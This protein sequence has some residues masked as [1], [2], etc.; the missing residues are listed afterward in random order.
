MCLNSLIIRHLD[1]LGYNGVDGSPVRET[2]QGLD[3]PSGGLS[4]PIGAFG[5]YG[6]SCTWTPKV[7]KIMAFWA[8]FSG[9]GPLFY[10]LWGSR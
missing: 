1:P 4:G 3:N 5:A 6:V 2:T 8:A 9:S 7:C 10:I